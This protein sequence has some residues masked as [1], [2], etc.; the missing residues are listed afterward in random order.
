MAGH[1]W[2]A[3]K[4]RCKYKSLLWVTG[5][6]LNMSQPKYLAVQN[7]AEEVGFVDLLT[8]RQNHFHL[9][10]AIHSAGMVEVDS[11]QLLD[12]TEI[13]KE[14]RKEKKILIMPSKSRKMFNVPFSHRFFLIRVLKD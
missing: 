5:S 7:G 13:I 1:I 8:G 10:M 4:W 6:H 14:I 3:E 12:T 9:V 11:T 2:T